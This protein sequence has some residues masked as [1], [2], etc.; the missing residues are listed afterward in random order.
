MVSLETERRLAEFLS[1]VANGERQVELARQSLSENPDFEP[2]S[3][4]KLVD[5]LDRASLG[6]F[7]LR[8]F[9]DYSRVVASEFEV[10][11]LIKQYDSDSDLRLT[12]G[13]FNQLVLPSARP[14]LRELA[15]SRP[16]YPRV[17][18]DVE[19]LFTRLLEKEILYQ[20]TIEDF[21]RSLSA[22]YDFNLLDAF[23]LIDRPS[24]A[25]ITVDKLYSFL[26]RNGI[27]VFEEDMDAILRRLDTDADG[28]LSYSEFIEAVLPSEPTYRPS[29]IPA[30]RSS[31]SR[32][33]ASPRYS[34]PL[35]RSGSPVRSGLLSSSTLSSSP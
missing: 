35:K 6:L 34:S 25:F 15:L 30:Y 20:R 13:D 21:K 16:S 5:K 26:R 11:Q 8:D 4:F 32:R 3:V 28:R 29:E 24:T 31:P 23:K 9:L 1:Q 14:T 19:Y 7:E 22:R 12:I 27:S 17:S 2:Y 18:V 33:A 10:S